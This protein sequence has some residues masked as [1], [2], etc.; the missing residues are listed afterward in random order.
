[1]SV[2]NYTVLSFLPP[3]DPTYFLQWPLAWLGLCRYSF[4]DKDDDYYVAMADRIER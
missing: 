3:F 2:L 1:M 4:V